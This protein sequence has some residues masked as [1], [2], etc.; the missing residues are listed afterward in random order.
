MDAFG[1]LSDPT[2]RR[3]VELLAVGP[4]SSGEIARQF[5]VSAP[6]ISQ[7]LK[8]LRAARVVRARA[9]AQR[10]IYELEAGGIEEVGRW[11]DQIRAFWAG[12][13]DQLEYELRKEKS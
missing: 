12:R 6:A 2:R 8:I 13:L 1:A 3:I 7:H 10:R 5:D 9:Q 11:L 4:L